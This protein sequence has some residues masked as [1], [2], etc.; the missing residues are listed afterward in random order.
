MFDIGWSELGIIAV[1]AVI[2]L[3]PKE[4]PRAMRTAGQWMRKLRL[5]ANDFQ[6]HLDDMVEEAELSDLRDQAKRLSGTNLTQELTKAVDPTGDMSRDLTNAEAEIRDGMRTESKASSDAASSAVP[7]QDASDG[8][9]VSGSPVSPATNADA[10]PSAEQA[11]KP[12]DA[13]EPV[14]TPVIDPSEKSSV[15]G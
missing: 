12:D 8:V 7:A 15:R 2:I 11:P 14:Q 6:K 3:G 1:L 9:D 13:A 5:L 10:L 4:L